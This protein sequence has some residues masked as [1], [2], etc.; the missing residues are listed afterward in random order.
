M[1]QSGN[2]L[3]P[4]EIAQLQAEYNQ[5]VANAQQGF[6]AL[7]QATGFTFGDTTGNQENS[8]AGGIKGITEE[9]ANV[10]AGQFG[11]LRM[12]AISQ[13][14]IATQQLDVLGQIQANT[15]VLVDM[16]NRIRRFD[17]VGIKII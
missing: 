7:Q 10:I 4:D 17:E 15:A 11:G 5:I 8:L 12:T 2:N 6:A 16:S 9:T 3:S 1:A 13:L 14:N